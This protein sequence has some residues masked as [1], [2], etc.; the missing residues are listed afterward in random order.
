MT[1]NF[2]LA[3]AAKTVDGLYAVCIDIQSI[4]GTVN[5]DATSMNTQADVTI[6]FIMGAEDGNPIFD[7]RQTI[8]QA[9]L[10]DTAMSVSQLAHHDFG[11]GANA[12]LRIVEQTLSA[13]STHTLRVVYELGLPQASSAGSYQPN[14]NWDA[15][16]RLT[17]NF[18]F[19]DLGAG[20]YL[21][22]W[23]P[24]NL[25]FDQY[26]VNL[27]FVI[28]NTTIAH[29]VISNGLITSVAS[30]SW[31]VQW[32]KHTS[33]FSTLLEI[34]AA[35]TLSSQSDTVTLPV[36]G[37]SI[38]IEAWKLASSSIDLTSQINAI[39]TFLS[40]NESNVGSYLHG[41]RFVVFFI[42][43]GMEYDGGTTT[44]T[45]PLHHETFHSWWGRGIKPASQND[46]WW[47]E[48]WTE[49]NMA[50]A[51]GSIPFDFTR[52]PVVLS[53][54]NPWNR[55][56]PGASYSSGELF[57][58]G[59]ASLQ[60]ASSLRD[61][62][63]DFYNN[64]KSKPTTTRA[65]ESHLLCRIG[66]KEIVDG[67]HRFIYGLSDSTSPPDLWLKDHP[68]HTGA[69]EWDGVF[70]NSPDLW[71]RHTDDESTVH[72]DPE[73]GQDNWFYARIRNR[74]IMNAQHLVVSFT[75][76]TYAGMQFSFPDDFLPCT[77]ATVEF[78][79]VAGETRI[80]KAKWP[81]ALVPPAG[82][83]SCL[84]A[85][86][87]ARGDHPSTGHRVWEHNNLAQKNL[88]VVDLAPNT[89]IVIPFLLT[90]LERRWF[91]W[92]HLELIRLENS[93]Y[94][95]AELMHP[96]LDKLKGFSWPFNNLRLSEKQQKVLQ[97]ET[98]LL[99]CGAAPEGKAKT[100]H[101]PWTSYNPDAGIADLFRHS[102]VLKFA[103]KHRRARLKL[104]LPHDQPYLFGL[105]I[106]A[107]ANAKS[108]SILRF[109]L[110]QKFW[111]CFKSI[112]GISVEIR[113][114]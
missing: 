55:K 2:E 41:N 83:H 103:N 110:A 46:G 30:N 7:L 25:I 98:D 101:L 108:G 59:L 100:N 93:D 54:L 5:F 11:G 43:G 87:L 19:T 21:E 57:F 20:R 78:N 27:N 29:E 15:G 12:E 40:D 71:I 61:A 23:I 37:D 50:G 60:N 36:S 81:R 34:R 89:W 91:P 88:T 96:L 28:E 9:W 31:Q 97:T 69:D 113:V 38:S 32:P 1:T 114:R 80:V 82:T 99:D 68:D 84:L 67:F 107:P 35:D 52:P 92:L 44:S 48:A 8:L 17:F 77:A 56:T 45:G 10:D 112:G 22:S 39:K 58:D 79:L 102:P 53:S 24:A 111:A 33:A 62:M 64:N 73:F 3:P 90:N 4:A 6:E 109:H 95:E 13:G 18:G 86:V 47:D 105:R 75:A 14:L 74:S 65:L 85:S 51:N 94:A 49:Y 66:K 42:T 76:Q 16:P 70:W 106:K 104:S 63:N 72:Q 26:E